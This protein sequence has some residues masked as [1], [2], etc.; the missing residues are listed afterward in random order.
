[1]VENQQAIRRYL[2]LDI[3]N[4]LP[5]HDIPSMDLITWHCRGAGNKKFK[6]TLRKLVHIQKPALVVLMEPKV[7]FKA[8]GMYFNCMGFTASTQVDPIGR[9]GG[10]WMIWNPNVVNVRVV[11]ACTQ[12]ITA[13]ISRQDFQDWVLSAVYASPNPNKRDELWEQLTTIAQSMDKPWLVAGDFNDFSSPN[14]KRSLQGSNTQS[15][16][17]D[18]RRSSKFNDRLNI[19]KLIDLGCASPQLTWS[20]NR[21]GW[22]STMVQLDRALCNTEW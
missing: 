18:L 21:K 13:I 12:P 22:A 3:Q 19:C 5:I 2:E 1:M 11:E 8:M 15:I 17:Q 20:N 6:K 10:I 7:E 9:S 14:E 4:P 16:N